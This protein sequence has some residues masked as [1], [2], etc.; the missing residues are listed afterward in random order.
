[1]VNNCR[2][3]L[4]QGG[5]WPVGSKLVFDQMAA[6]VPEIMDINGKF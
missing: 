4:L 6:L 3:G 5:W 1:M 2:R